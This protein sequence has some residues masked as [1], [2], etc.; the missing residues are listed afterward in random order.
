MNRPTRG[1]DHRYQTLGRQVYV[2]DTIS[3]LSCA[4]MVTIGSPVPRVPT[5]CRH[6]DERDEGVEGVEGVKSAKSADTVSTRCRHGVEGVKGVKGVEEAKG[7]KGA[8]TVSTR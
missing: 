5:R 2:L 3:R 6:G 8:D 7:A 1:Y 4:W